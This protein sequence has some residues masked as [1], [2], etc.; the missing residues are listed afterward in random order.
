MTKSEQRLYIRKLT[1]VSWGFNW[2]TA[3]NLRCILLNFIV[4]P[5]LRDHPDERPTHMA[6]P[7][8]DVN[9]NMKLLVFNPTMRP[10][11]ITGH[12][13]SAKGVAL[14]EGLHYYKHNV[15]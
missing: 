10:P 14:Q 6:R 12:L 1:E 7:H 9:L 5:L 3:P 11:L 15:M 2:A 8:D 4:K 13:S